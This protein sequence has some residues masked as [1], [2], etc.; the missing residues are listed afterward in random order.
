METT[1]DDPQAQGA[2]RRLRGRLTL[3]LLVLAFALPLAVATWLYRNPQ[4]WTPTTFTNHGALVDPPRPL[5]PLDLVELTGQHFG[6]E[7]L[8]G[9]WTLMHI[10]DSRCDSACEQAL[11]KTRQLRL[12]LGHDIDRVQRV[13]LATESPLLAPLA[14]V[15]EEHPRLRL[16]T[17]DRQALT[18]V[19][20]LLGEDALGTV[21][22]LDPLGNLVLG[23]RPG[24]DARGM[25]K[26][27]KR[28]LRNSR[29]G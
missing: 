27:V 24:F 21:F 22:L 20:A 29:I 17:G 8:R 25:F 26:D 4:V 6:V 16:V 19:M 3:I 5:E 10:E 14:P 11:V 23:Y 1:T 2:R 15:L 12:A 28:L 9:Y 13:Y 7:Q 18:P